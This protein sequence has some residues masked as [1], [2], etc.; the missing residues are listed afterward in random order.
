M[1]EIKFRAWHGDHKKMEYPEV[2]LKA[3]SDS[4][5]GVYGS[6]CGII[7]SYFKSSGDRVWMEYIGRKDKNDKEVYEGDVVECYVLT[8]HKSSRRDAV[9]CIVEFKNGMFYPKPLNGY[10]FGVNF[11]NCII[12]GNI[13]QNPDFIK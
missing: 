3:D 10:N 9:I 11:D 13:Y 2:Q 7:N 12:L 6:V 1:R 5:D 4:W 8:S